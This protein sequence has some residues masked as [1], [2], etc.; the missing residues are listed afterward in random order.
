MRGCER[1]RR[2]R[3]QRCLIGR[4]RRED[5]AVVPHNNISKSELALRFRYSRND[6]GA[7]GDGAERALLVHAFERLHEPRR[8]AREA[9][10]TH[11]LRA[12]GS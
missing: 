10:S 2:L 7:L 11:N 3:H 1:R 9:N 6:L 12:D 4:C 5:A 8:H